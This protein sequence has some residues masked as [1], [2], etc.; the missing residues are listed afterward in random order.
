VNVFALPEEL[1]E[2][3]LCE[4]IAGGEEVL[5]ERIVSTGQFTPPDEWLSQERDE[6]VVVL[7]GEAELSFADG[8]RTFLGPGDDAL[9]PSGARHRVERTSAE[10]PCIWLAV[11]GSGL[12]R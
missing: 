7:Q 3:E 6:W 5:I 10:P 9:V 1:P 12:A 2:E 11:H 8:S 4:R